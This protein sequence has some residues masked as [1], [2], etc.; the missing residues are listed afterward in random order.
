MALLAALAVPCLAAGSSA[1]QMLTQ[2]ANDSISST[3]DPG[4][5]VHSVLSRP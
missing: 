4:P 2:L 3:N 1:E 5:Q